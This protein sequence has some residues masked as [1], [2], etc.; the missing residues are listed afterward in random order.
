MD[1]QNFQS[2]D[3]IISGQFPSPKLNIDAWWTDRGTAMKVAYNNITM[4]VLC[5]ILFLMIITLVRYNNGKII[6]DSRNYPSTESDQQ[7]EPRN[8]DRWGH[9]ACVR[10]DGCRSRLWFGWLGDLRLGHIRW[11]AQPE[12]DQAHTWSL[13]SLP[14]LGMVPKQSIYEDFKQFRVWFWIYIY[15]YIAMGR[16]FFSI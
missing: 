5:C 4:V 3:L 9:P 2:H 10:L 1:V 8:Q 12:P 7:R 11:S 15:I 6:I 16:A 14:M 13:I